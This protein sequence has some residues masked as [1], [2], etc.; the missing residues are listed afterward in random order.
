M[1]NVWKEHMIL[2][3]GESR[4]RQAL[5]GTEWPGWKVWWLFVGQHLHK[6]FNH[7]VP[8]EE[9]KLA[10]P[11]TASHVSLYSLIKTRL[12]RRALLWNF[13]FPT[14]ISLV[15]PQISWSTHPAIP[16]TWSFEY[17]IEI[18]STAYCL[19]FTAPGGVYTCS[20]QSVNTCT[21]SIPIRRALARSRKW[22]GITTLPHL[23]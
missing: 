4:V 5:S 22:P 23:L 16:C 20:C 11:I 2:L 1:T 3:R 21:Y 10:A 19:T 14:S 18:P 13:K 12:I 6:C 7:G 17:C 9:V 8:L 15:P